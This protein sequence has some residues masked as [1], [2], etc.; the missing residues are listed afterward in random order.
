MGSRAQSLFRQNHIEV[1]INVM[2]S[3]LEKAVMDYI[4]G[5]LEVGDDVCGH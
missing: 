5:T 2:E 1:V 3:D 4:G